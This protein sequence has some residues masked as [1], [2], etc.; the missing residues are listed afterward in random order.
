MNVGLNVGIRVDGL[1]VG[2]R[3]DGLAVGCAVGLGE[4]HPLVYRGGPNWHFPLEHVSSPDKNHIRRGIPTNNQHQG[5][6][7]HD[8]R[9]NILHE[10]QGHKIM[11]QKLQT[12]HCTSS[13]H[14]N[15]NS[16]NNTMLTE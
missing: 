14:R 2:L 6:N 15:L 10:F 12:Y 8:R 1:A 13:H 11:E 9:P 5:R 16:S 4:G 3:V 7:N